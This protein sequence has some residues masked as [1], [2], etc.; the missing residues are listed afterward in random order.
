MSSELMENARVLNNI[1]SVPNRVGLKRNQIY[2]ETYKNHLADLEEKSR[3][4]SYD[5]RHILKEL[6][7]AAAEKEQNASKTNE[8][9][10]SDSKETK[11]ET[12]AETESP[13]EAA[14]DNK[15]TTEAVVENS[16]KLLLKLNFFLFSF[17]FISIFYIWILKI[18]FLFIL[19]FD[20]EQ[21]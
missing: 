18:F 7:D 6:N 15:T 17:R 13:K 14:D 4:S 21:K 2:N 12:Q 9:S 16:W 3:T 19:F 20:L 10:T 11:P 8:D 5:L 1:M